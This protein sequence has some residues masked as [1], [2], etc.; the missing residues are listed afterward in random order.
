VISVAH[1]SLQHRL[2]LEA[3]SEDLDFTSR[4]SKQLTIGRQDASL[5]VRTN[6]ERQLGHPTNRPY[7]RKG[8]RPV[9]ERVNIHVVE[10]SVP[11]EH[12]DPADGLA[13]RIEDL[14]LDGQGTG[15]CR[16]HDLDEVV[17]HETNRPAAALT[18]RLDK[19]VLPLA[20]QRFDTVE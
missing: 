17:E 5:A 8:K 11:D 13:V 20:P 18:A 15:C 2:H 7:F 1:P 9:A 10:H 6:A 12:D 19:R 14:A 4:R 3:P 16:W